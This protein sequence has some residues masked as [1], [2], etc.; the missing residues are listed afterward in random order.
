M[1]WPLLTVVVLLVAAMAMFAANRPRMD[2]VAVLM[3]VALPLT[4]VLSVE[5]TLAGFADPNVVLIAALFVI[6]EALSRTGI[7]YWLGDGLA[8]TAGSSA[9]RLLVLLMVAVA[10][11]GAFMSSTGVVAIFVPV[12]L[13]I[14]R[15]LG[16]SAR[17]LMM[18]LSMA[19][20]ISG[21]LT[22][23]A[24]APNL[25]VDAELA[26]TGSHGLGFFSFTPFGLVV[27]AVGVG[28]MLLARRLLGDDP[29]PGAAGGRRGFAD[30]I[31]DYRLTG[32]DR[33]LRVT[34]TSSLAGR[35]LDEP[36]LR[37]G[38]G[39]IV[40]AVERRGLLSRQTRVLSANARVR[41]RPGD[42]VL[43]HLLRTGPDVDAALRELRLEELPLE[44]SAVTERSREIGLAELMLAPSSAARGRTVA[45]LA[46][47]LADGVDV[48]GLRRGASAVAGAL[49]L[50]RVGLGD[51]LLVMGPW[52][53][54]RRLTARGG[55]FVA[56]DLPGEAE[57]TAPAAHRAPFALAALAL[58]IVLMVTGVVPNVVAALAAC[59]LMG[60]AGC[61]D[62]PAAYRAIHWPTLL[63]IVGMLPFAAAL[64]QTGGIDLAVDALLHVFGAASP[65]VMLAALFAVTALIGLFVSNTATAVLMAP[66]AIGI[67]DKLGAS[68][69][70]FAMTVALAASAAFMT[71]VSSP[72]NTLVLGPGGYRFADFVKVGAPFTVLVLVVTVVMVPWLLPL[73]PAS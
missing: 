13:S 39:A 49:D 72:V 3:L 46:R 32:R 20:L 53:Q 48:I 28:Y 22:L 35:H 69:Y 55:D 58:M 45:E 44:G 26:R 2:V 51:T 56:L 64:K 24:T 25:V 70:P 52:P 62:M 6:G 11:L 37:S 21:M 5:Q 12:V 41:L 67:A 71:P 33:R 4:G 65:T 31:A 40:L 1:N 23:I 17:Q 14:S 68:P 47:G 16:V 66:V 36:A 34:L 59:L 27:L 63:L 57:Q 54:V 7:T 29:V 19:G 9:A 43:V 61:I 10:G 50:E 18:P 15:R 60:L 30:L 38:A 42:V 73:Y 8:A